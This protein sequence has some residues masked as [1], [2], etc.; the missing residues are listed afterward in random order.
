MKHEL[1]LAITK[2]VLHFTL[3]LNLP[4]DLEYTLSDILIHNSNLCSC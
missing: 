4:L 2:L 1:I 3:F